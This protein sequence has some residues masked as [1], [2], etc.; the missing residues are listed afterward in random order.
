M[1]PDQSAAAVL[2]QGVARRLLVVR[3]RQRRK[4]LIEQ[5][6]G[7]VPRKRQ[8]SQVRAPL[9]PPAPSSVQG[10]QFFSWPPGAGTQTDA[11]ACQ[12][13]CCDT[14]SGGPNIHI[15]L[16]GAGCDA[17]SVASGSPIADI[18]LLGA[19]CDAS[20]VASGSSITAFASSCQHE[21]Q[22]PQQGASEANYA[23]VPS[24]LLGERKSSAARA[25][26][27]KEGLAWLLCGLGGRPGAKLAPRAAAPVDT[28]RIRPPLYDM[29]DLPQLS[30]SFVA[31]PIMPSP[32]SPRSFVAP[33]EKPSSTPPTPQTPPTAPTMNT[34]LLPQS[35]PC[36]KSRQPSPPPRSATARF[37]ESSS[38]ISPETLAEVMAAEDLTP[39]SPPLPVPLRTPARLPKLPV[40]VTTW[41][42]KGLSAKGRPAVRR[43]AKTKQPKQSNRD[44]SPKVLGV[45]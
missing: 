36:T 41:P 30:K 43:D 8:P 17:A 40:A 13:T 25:V 3:D 31:P 38:P 10:R 28:T 42:L 35:M 19:G 29:A 39:S 5:L 18:H 20:S 6:G 45:F 4:L 26:I 14:S 23:E 9:P 12:S 11:S 15:H 7:Q 1:T 22:S 34:P 37:P 33:P 32:A 44:C 27:G 21:G 2:I 24:E 16:N